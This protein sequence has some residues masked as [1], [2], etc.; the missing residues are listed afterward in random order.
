[1][2]IEG[3]FICLR[4]IEEEDLVFLRDLRGDPVNSAMLVGRSFPLSMLEQARRYHASVGVPRTHR[5]I[6][7]HKDTY[8]LLG[9]TDLWDID[10]KD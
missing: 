6:I 9:F 3:K 5:F 4:A 8:A 1:M 10:W 2:G 7:E